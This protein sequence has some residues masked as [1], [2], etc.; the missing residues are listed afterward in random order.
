MYTITNIHD[1]ISF[2]TDCASEAAFCESF[3]RCYKVTCNQP[4]LAL[5][6]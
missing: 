4:A 2:K 5:A 1:G 6:A 3:P